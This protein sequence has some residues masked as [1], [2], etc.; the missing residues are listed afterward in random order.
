M[1]PIIN[2]ASLNLSVF[3]TNIAEKIIGKGSM[4]RA[5]KPKI[6]KAD[7]M[8]GLAAYVWRMVAFSISPKSQHHCM[9]IMADFD[10]WDCVPDHYIPTIPAEVLAANIAK[11]NPNDESYI[12]ERAHLYPYSNPPRAPFTIESYYANRWIE[13]DR[14]KHFTKNMLNPLI[15]KITHS[16][17]KSQWSGVHRWARAMGV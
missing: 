16:V 14:R 12:T 1:M 5:S 8:T 3:E 4:L 11:M 6:N 10:M 2:L 15:D 17:P 7:P 9:P 13:S